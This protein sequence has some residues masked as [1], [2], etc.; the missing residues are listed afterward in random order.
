MNILLALAHHDRATFETFRQVELLHYQ[1]LNS[2]FWLNTVVG[3][4]TLCILSEATKLI[5]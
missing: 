3:S 5:T 2:F 4:I 1:S